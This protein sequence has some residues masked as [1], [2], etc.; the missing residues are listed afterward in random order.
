VGVGERVREAVGV[1]GGV[2]TEGR[3]WLG[4]AVKLGVE[5]G[6]D[7]VD[8]IAQAASRIAIRPVNIR[9]MTIPIL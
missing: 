6:L 7:G 2:M 4:A 8:L 3:L 5:V 9:F 1:A